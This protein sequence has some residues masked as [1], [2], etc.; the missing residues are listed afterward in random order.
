MVSNL[1]SRKFQFGVINF[2]LLQHERR[3]LNVFGPVSNLQKDRFDDIDRVSAINEVS[4]NT[5]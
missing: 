5:V 2:F 3:S 4:A 1:G